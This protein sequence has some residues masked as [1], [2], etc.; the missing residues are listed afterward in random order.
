MSRRSEE[1]PRT[2][3][4]T[5]SIKFITKTFLNNSFSIPPGSKKIKFLHFLLNFSEMSKGH[6]NNV[7]RCPQDANFEHT[8]KNKLLLKFFFFGS[9][10]TKCVAWNIKNLVGETDG[11]SQSITKRCSE[12]SALGTCQFWNYDLMHFRCITLFQQMGVWNTKGLVVVY[13]YVW[14]ETSQRCPL[15]VS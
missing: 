3:I 9:Y 13:S 14:G 2:S 12:V 1:V 6:F 7:S 4:L 5:H 15:N 10:F 11:R 8:L